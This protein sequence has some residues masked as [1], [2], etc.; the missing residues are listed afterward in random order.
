M[1]SAA[2]AKNFAATECGLEARLVDLHGHDRRI[3]G[4]LRR[5]LAQHLPELTLE[6]PHAGLA[7]VV[8][9]D[10]ADRGVVDLDLVGP[11]PVALELRGA[12]GGRGR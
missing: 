5:D 7:G 6:G 12:A 8:R 1:R 10:V 2:S 3:G 4:D 11:Q 9:D